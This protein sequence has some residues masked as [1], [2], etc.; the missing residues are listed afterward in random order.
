VTL[1]GGTH[2]VTVPMEMVAHTLAP[3]QSVTV[4]V[5]ASAINFLN[6]YSWGAITV[7]EMS[8]SLPTLATAGAVASGAAQQPVAVA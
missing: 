3:G 6:F 2:T 5:V 1:D 8:V 7:E 4:Q